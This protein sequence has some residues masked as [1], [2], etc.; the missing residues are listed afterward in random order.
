[1]LITKEL[2]KKIEKEYF[3][4][5]GKIEIDSNYFIEKIKQS[6]S[7]NLNLNYKTNVKSLMTPWDF[8]VNDKKFIQIIINFVDYIDK[9]YNM[10]SYKLHEAW[11]IQVKPNEKTNFH[12][13]YQTLWSGVLYLNSS[14]QNLIFP[15]IKEEVKP[16][17]GSFALFSNFLNHGCE[18]NKEDF[19]KFGISFN[20]AEVK[21]F[22]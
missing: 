8:F 20:F 14:K 22:Q 17:P 4:I 2:N 21:N 3:F 7:S 1:M 5:K 9:N 12:T 16:E 13:H 18:R 6:C 11:G 15:D 19:S 10:V